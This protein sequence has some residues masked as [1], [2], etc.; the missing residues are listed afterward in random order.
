[1]DIEVTYPAH[2]SLM[3]NG[4][5]RAKQILL[6]HDRR[7]LDMTEVILDRDSTAWE[8]M[9]RSFRPN[10]TPLEARLAFLETISHLEHLKLVGKIRVEQREDV[11]VFTR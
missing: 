3:D 6:H 10:L 11:L 1:M 9:L 5:E 8:V 7:L 4:D 2:G